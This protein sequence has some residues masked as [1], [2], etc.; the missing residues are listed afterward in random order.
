[1]KDTKSKKKA[2]STVT[3]PLTVHLSFDAFVQGRS[4]F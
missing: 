2:I 1:M 4:N 3:L